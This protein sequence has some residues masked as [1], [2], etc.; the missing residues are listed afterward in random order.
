MRWGTFHKGVDISAPYGTPIHATADGTIEFASIGNG[1]GKEVVIDHGGG[2][3]TL[4]AHMSGFHCTVGDQVVRGQII[5]YVG[6][7]GRSTGAHVHYEVHL[8]NVPV[9]PHKYLQSTSNAG[10]FVVDSSLQCLLSA[11]MVQLIRLCPRRSIMFSDP[12]LPSS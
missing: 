11:C 3:K 5:G 7:T 4:Y 6:M 12:H 10:R 8:R 1:F 2:V 9:N